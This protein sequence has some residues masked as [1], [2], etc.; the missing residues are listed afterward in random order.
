MNCYNK[1]FN[2]I[3]KN[4]NRIIPYTLLKLIVKIHKLGVACCIT[5]ARYEMSKMAVK[6]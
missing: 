2:L 5:M 1:H 3:M 6:N 4:L